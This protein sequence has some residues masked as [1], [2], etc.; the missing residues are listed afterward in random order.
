[1]RRNAS[2]IETLPHEG[3]RFKP[4]VEQIRRVAVES[5]HASLDKELAPFLAF[6]RGESELDTLDRDAIA[7]A[8]HAFEEALRDAPGYAQAHVGL[9]MACG[10]AFEAS[11][12]D[13]EPDRAA[14]ERGVRHAEEGCR[15]DSDCAEAWSALSFVLYLSGETQLA[16][17]AAY[18][19]RALEP[20]NWRHA[21]RAGYITW[22]EQRMR[23]AHDVLR[24][25]ELALAYWL[26]AS[27]LIARGALDQALEVLRLG[28]AAQDAQIAGQGLPGI[29]LHLLHG[30]ALA[31]LNQLD[32]AEAALTRELTWADSGQV[33]ARECA[34]N[35]WYALGAINLRQGKRAE[36]DAAFRRTLSIAP[37]HASATAALHGKV[38]TPSSPPEGGPYARELDG[39]LGRAIVLARSNRH[40]DAA[41]IYRDAIAQA[42]PGCAGWQLPI[43]PLI[44]PLAHRQHWDDVLA[45]IRHR[46][47]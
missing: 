1:V 8:Q 23:A 7:R 24:C 9:A 42:A 3:Y 11:I 2:H 41:R 45:I 39:A 35:T 28:C 26:Q 16:A 30:Q 46:A 38:L 14:L 19:A 12:T 4:T 20:D 18:K 36:A 31:A 15:R 47:L 44:N 29:G 17:A 6:V 37:R 13:V 32:E 21:L 40:A 43:E 33:Y 10:L 34:S 22:G 25:V 5:G 27:V